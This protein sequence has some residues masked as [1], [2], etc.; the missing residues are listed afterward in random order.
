MT[1]CGPV[2]QGAVSVAGFLGAG[3]E[4]SFTQRVPQSVFKCTTHSRYTDRLKRRL[5]QE[6][7]VTTTKQR[8]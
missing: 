1:Q 8:V 4:W 6:E 5:T 7:S 3:K 2:E